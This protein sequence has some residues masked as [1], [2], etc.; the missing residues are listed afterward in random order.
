MRYD[1][2]MFPIRSSSA[3]SDHFLVANG[4][5]VVGEASTRNQ[6][7]GYLVRSINEVHIGGSHPVGRREVAAS[8]LRNSG[9]ELIALQKELAWASSYQPTAAANP[10]TAA[11]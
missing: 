3:S 6:L 5:S 7:N 8:G 4:R 11:Q 9:L 2:V 1:L 10:R